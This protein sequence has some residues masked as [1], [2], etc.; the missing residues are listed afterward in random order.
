MR[1]ILRDPAE[2][3]EMCAESLHP[4]PS[5]QL[6]AAQHQPCKLF[7]LQGFST[8]MSVNKAQRMFFYQDTK[9]E[10]H[11]PDYMNVCMLPKLTGTEIVCLSRH[12][13]ETVE[14]PY[15]TRSTEVVLVCIYTTE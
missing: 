8:Q 3:A 11:L 4:P 9:P 14:M 13:G 15:K 10:R 7:V 6:P 2:P 5:P 1:G 12:R